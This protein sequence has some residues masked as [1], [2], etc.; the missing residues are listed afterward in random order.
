MFFSLHFEWL[1]RVINVIYN[2]YNY[3]TNNI[4]TFGVNFHEY[5]ILHDI[6]LIF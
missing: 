2:K 1:H 6:F 3:L 5:A 4:R